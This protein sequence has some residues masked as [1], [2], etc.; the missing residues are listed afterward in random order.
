MFDGIVP[1]IAR[2]MGPTWGPSGADR[3]QVG[4]MLAPWTLLSGSFEDQAPVDEI[5]GCAIFEWLAIILIS[6]IGHQ[7]NSFSNGCHG[8]MSY[9]FLYTQCAEMANVT[10]SYRELF[11]I[12]LTNKSSLFDLRIVIEGFALRYTSLEWLQ[13]SAIKPPA[14]QLFIQQFPRVI[15][16]ENIKSSHWRF[17]HHF[18]AT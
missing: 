17:V 11:L 13:L 2:F 7:D 5:Y 16:K 3:T 10:Q 9:S 1:L 15:I 14:I 18:H 12:R 8:H 6:K 4:P